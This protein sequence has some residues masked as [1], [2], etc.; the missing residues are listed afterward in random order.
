[1]AVGEHK[2]AS[3]DGRTWSVG[4]SRHWRGLRESG[5]VPYFWAHVIVTTIMVVVFLFVLRSE[6]FKVLS[7]LIVIVFLVWLVGFLNSHFR[8]T[9]TADTV[10]PPVDHRLWVVTKRRRRGDCVR[11]L[12]DAIQKGQDA[13][14]PQGTRLEEI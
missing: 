1:M 14:E 13:K 5:Q 11:E 3:P 10:G 7:L 9:I 12:E 4:T 2:V 8:V 6:V